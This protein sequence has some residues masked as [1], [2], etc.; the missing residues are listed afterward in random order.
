MKAQCGYTVIGC[1]FI[2]HLLLCTAYQP[3]SSLL[4]NGKAAQQ[5]HNDHILWFQSS[6]LLPHKYWCQYHLAELIT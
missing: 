4:F 3:P 6:A 2:A 5:N 1:P